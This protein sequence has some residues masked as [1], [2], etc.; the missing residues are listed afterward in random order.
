MGTSE[1]SCT[2]NFSVVAYRLFCFHFRSAHTSDQIWRVDLHCSLS[3][4]VLS[5]QINRDKW[6]YFWSLLKLRKPQSSPVLLNKNMKFIHLAH[7]HL[8]NWRN[9]LFQD[10]DNVLRQ[11]MTSFEWRLLY[12]LLTPLHAGDNRWCKMVNQEFMNNYLKRFVCSILMKEAERMERAPPLPP[13]LPSLQEQETGRLWHIN[14]TWCKSG[15]LR[16][17]TSNFD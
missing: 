1:R 4:K 11:R 15:R 9:P 3:W 14:L 5:S 10:V 8:L 13:P 16:Q 2:R 12:P 6:L 7:N 17:R